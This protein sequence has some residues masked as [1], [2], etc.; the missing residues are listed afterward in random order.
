LITGQELKVFIRL[1]LIVTSIFI[2]TSQAFAEEPQSELRLRLMRIAQHEFSKHIQ[3]SRISGLLTPLTP[4]ENRFRTELNERSG[5]EISALETKVLIRN[6]QQLPR[7]KMLRDLAYNL[8]ER[9]C[10][11]PDAEGNETDSARHFIAGFAL[12]LMAGEKFAYQYL[13]AHEAWLIE[14]DP[15]QFGAYNFASAIMDFHNNVVGILAARSAQMRIPGTEITVHVYS[16]RR[17][18]QLAVEALKKARRENRLMAVYNKNGAC[19]QASQ[20]AFLRRALHISSDTSI[21]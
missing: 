11:D 13:T 18:R 15:D 21:W 10:D 2:V 8:S 14:K 9:L 16:V 17:I 7:V 1:S 19:A 3:R 20:K 4:I 6:P 5:N 12:S